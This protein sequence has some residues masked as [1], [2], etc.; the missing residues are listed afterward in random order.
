MAAPSATRILTVRHGESEWNAVGRWQGQA[1]PPL[2][3]NGLVQAY[4]AAQSLG[5]FDAVWASTL[6]RAAH[7][8]AVIAEVIGVGPVQLHP[9]LMESDL[10]PWQGLTTSEIEAGW[11]N[12]IADGQR[13][14]GAETID[15]LIERGTAALRHIADAS[16][17]GE[18]LVV[19]HA[20]L[21]RALAMAAG[22]PALRL[23][24]L[25]ACW[26]T[27]HPDGRLSV[28]DPVHLIEHADG[29][30]TL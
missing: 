16:P 8:A 15:Q 27:V 26:F 5:T 12:F 2:T 17:A 14:E 23:T 6:Q 25:G 13:P 1:D 22:N 24:N 10:G 29:T 30:G 4:T 19:S 21:I 28:S 11:P 3:E 18:V 20:G 7:T 9:G